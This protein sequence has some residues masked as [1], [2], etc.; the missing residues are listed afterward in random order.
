MSAFGKYKTRMIR[1][2]IC[3]GGDRGEDG[4]R[5][6]LEVVLAVPLVVNGG[7]ELAQSSTVEAARVRELLPQ[8]Y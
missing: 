2:M 1:Y 3:M 6:T 4:G 7:E 5:Y 8:S